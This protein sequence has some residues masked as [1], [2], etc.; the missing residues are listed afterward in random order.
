MT[1]NAT[2]TP[3][4]DDL[5]ATALDIAGV[6][7][8]RLKDDAPELPDRTVDLKNGSPVAGLLVVTHY[9]WFVDELE[10][11]LAWHIMVAPDDFAE[12]YIR[13]RMQLTPTRAF[14]LDSWS[15][16]LAGGA[17][18]ITEIPAPGEVTR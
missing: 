12:L 7:L 15:T 5:E 8:E 10:I 2:A 17:F 16:A 13:P 9:A 14:R 6:F 1:I 4:V 18:T 11:G 3:G